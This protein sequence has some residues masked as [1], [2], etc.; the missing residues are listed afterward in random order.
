MLYITGCG[1]KRRPWMEGQVAD[2]NEREQDSLDS[3][4][5]EVLRDERIQ[6]EELRMILGKL[7]RMGAQTQMWTDKFVAFHVMVCY[8]TTYTTFARF[9]Y[10]LD[11]FG[12]CFIPVFLI[13]MLVIGLPLAY[14]EMTLG[15]FTTMTA[16]LVFRRIAPIA[17]GLGISM[18]IL[19]L[20]VTLVDF[21][22]IFSLINVVI[23]SMQIYTNEMPWHR[24]TNREDGPACKA[25]VKCQKQYDEDFVEKD[26][27]E[28]YT[29]QDLGVGTDD[30]SWTKRYNVKSFGGDCV[31]SAINLNFD[32]ESS[33]VLPFTVTR[34]ALPTREFFLNK[35]GVDSGL[36]SGFGYPS[37]DDIFIYFI[38]WLLLFGLLM[39]GRGFFLKACVVATIVFNSIMFTVISVMLVTQHDAFMTMLTEVNL[40]V[41]VW[42][43]GVLLTLVTLRIGQG[44]LFYLGSQNKFTN[45]LFVDVIAVV[46][47]MFVALVLFA[48]AHTLFQVTGGPYL[49]NYDALSY[50]IYRQ[51]VISESIYSQFLSYWTTAANLAVYGP[52]EPFLHLLLSCSFLLLALVNNALA[53]ESMVT[54]CVTTLDLLSDDTSR[55]MIARVTVLFFALLSFIINSEFGFATVVT[56][57]STVIPMATA[58][59]VLLELFVV[60]VLYGF[61]RVHANVLSMDSGKQEDKFLRILWNLSYYLLWKL[62]PFL[63]LFGL[64]G[65]FPWPPPTMKKVAFIIVALIL[66]PTPLAAISEITLAIG[67]QRNVRSILSPEYELWGPR[68]TDDR[69]RAEMMEKKVRNYRYLDYF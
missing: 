3:E 47:Y 41:E 42:A 17:S 20:L 57:E 5:L 22:F 6:D 13:C 35:I 34:Y 28:K 43:S 9:C 2:D 23:H 55:K 61:F 44:G 12:I 10:F 51:S 36:P 38:S 48:T 37:R 59:V 53:L 7:T 52:F 8:M 60:G 29:T 33:N 69:K 58:L 31:R 49:F 40:G 62:S 65:A 30:E 25:L 56:I 67:N 64:F 39:Q 45:N 27:A 16:I 24:C 21:S 26:F 50:D 63:I 18:F 46:I 11:K 19:G 15:Q 14:L 68:M 54:N 1:I 4:S 32:M 66:L